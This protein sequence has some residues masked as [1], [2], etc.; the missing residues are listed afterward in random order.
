MLTLVGMPDDD[1][2]LMREEHVAE[3][4]RE[5]LYKSGLVLREEGRDI[6]GLW[7]IWGNDLVIFK[8][9]I[10]RKVWPAFL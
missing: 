2:G 8:I 6:N 9:Y 7:Q 1:F 4:I 3:A 10:E 5:K